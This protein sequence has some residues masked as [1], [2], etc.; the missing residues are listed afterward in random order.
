RLVDFG[1]PPGLVSL[2]FEERRH[3]FPITVSKLRLKFLCSPP[4]AGD[5]GDAC[6][7]LGRLVCE[8][9]LFL[10]SLRDPAGDIVRSGPGRPEIADGCESPLFEY[11]TAARTPLFSE[12]FRAGARLGCAR[13]D[14]D[15][16]DIWNSQ[17]DRA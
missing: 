9:A 16:H 1:L 10:A 13:E 11:R 12:R 15:L 14:L 2:A 8:V 5:F 3:G 4:Q 6:F 17:V 7:Q